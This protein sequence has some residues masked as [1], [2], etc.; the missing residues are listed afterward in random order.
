MSQKSVN[1]EPAG[2]SLKHSQ[3]SILRLGSS[4]GGAFK[5]QHPAYKTTT[6]QT[7]PF[8][9]PPG[10]QDTEKPVELKWIMG[11]PRLP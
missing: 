7:N 8:Y 4:T 9:I 6:G 10:L 1:F 5:T 2:C 11:S 3:A